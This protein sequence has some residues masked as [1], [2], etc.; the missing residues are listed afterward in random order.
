M[1]SSAIIVI[2]HLATASAFFTIDTVHSS[3]FVSSPFFREL[4]AA[5]SPSW[6]CDSEL[7]SITYPASH[8]EAESIRLTLDDTGKQL[9]LSGERKIEGCTCQPRDDVTISLPFTPRVEDIKSTLDNAERLTITLSKHAKMKEPVAI[10]IK[11][12]E[13]LAEATSTFRFVPHASA[14]AASAE[15]KMK[16]AMDKF[17][18][19]AAFASGV[20]TDDA[21]VDVKGTATNNDT[22][23]NGT[24]A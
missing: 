22:T 24:A 13:P 16:D 21:E 19:V 2:S 4:R 10:M 23:A 5:A 18:A 6:S 12:P 7:C 15:E 11:K 20:K 8:L 9:T 3:P 1:S 14:T 17:R